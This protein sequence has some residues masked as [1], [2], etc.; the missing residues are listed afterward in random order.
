[1]QV[2]RV[3]NCDH[4]HA[5]PCGD[6]TTA[7]CVVVCNHLLAFHVENCEAKNYLIL[8]SFRNIKSYKFSHVIYFVC[9]ACAIFNSRCSCFYILRTILLIQSSIFIS[10]DLRHSIN[11]V[12]FGILVKSITFGI[13]AGL[14]V[15]DLSTKR[16]TRRRVKAISKKV[17]KMATYPQN[18]SHH[19]GYPKRGKE[20]PAARSV[21]VYQGPK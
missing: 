2:E 13:R 10:L 17:E 18:E 8:Q 15:L 19:R 20:L 11:I 3:S 14:Y 7:F 1:M 5:S 6:C 9:V 4:P 12:V 21:V 16:S